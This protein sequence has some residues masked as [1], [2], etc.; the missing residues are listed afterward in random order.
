MS[1]AALLCVQRRRV[2]PL[3]VLVIGLEELMR[4]T[5]MAVGYTKESFTFF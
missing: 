1:V 2:W 5:D 3:R 4:K